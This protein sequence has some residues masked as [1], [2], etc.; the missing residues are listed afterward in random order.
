MTTA[1]WLA[2]AYLETGRGRFD[3]AGPLLAECA[4][5]TARAARSCGRPSSDATAGAD[6]PDERLSAAAHLPAAR[7]ARSEIL[8]VIAWM[9]RRG[10]IETP[11]KTA[12]A[13]NLCTWDPG[14]FSSLER[15]AGVSLGRRWR[16]EAG[17]R[18]AAPQGRRGRSHTTIPG[19]CE[20]ARPSRSGCR[21]CP[22]RQTDRAAVECAQLVKVAVGRDPFLAAEADAGESDWPQAGQAAVSADG[23]TGGLAR[24]CPAKDGVEKLSVAT[25]LYHRSATKLK[26]GAEFRSTTVPAR[27]NT[28]PKR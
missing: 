12:L 15:L 19:S 2:R 3:E 14:D 21:P 20:R 8:A 4:G 26:L 7:V 25:L 24:S 5:R 6:R 18:M 13:E 9:A 28:F 16:Y 17:Y 27:T 23:S 11:E 1:V 22:P 10:V